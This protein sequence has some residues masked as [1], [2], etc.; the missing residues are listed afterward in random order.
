[1][2]K[3]DLRK[4]FGYPFTTKKQVRDAMNYK[5]Y[6]EIRKFFYGLAC[7]GT[8]YWTDDVIEKVL[9]EVSYGD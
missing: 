8:R 4:A 5:Q 3:Q 7:V 9:A 6:N 2:T 1:M